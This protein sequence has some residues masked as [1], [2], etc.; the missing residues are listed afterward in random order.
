M[1]ID[2]NKTVEILKNSDDILILM[3]ASP[4]GDTVGSGYA[5]YYALT[6]MGKRAQLKCADPIPNKYSYFT[7][8]AECVDFEPNMIIAI[9]VADPK[10]LGEALGC[11][12]D[13][14]DLNIDH[15]KSNLDYAKSTYVIPEASSTCE[16]MFDIISSITEITPCIAD[17]LYTGLITDSGCFMYSCTSA[18]THFVGAK[19]IEKGADYVEINRRMFDTKTKARILVEKAVLNDMRF[20]ADDRISLIAVDQKLLADAGACDEDIEGIASISRIVEGVEIG[21][22]LKQKA[23]KVYKISCRTTKY[24]DAS[25]LC[26]KFGGGGHSRA[27]G[28]TI[29]GDKEEVIS[30]FVEEAKK[31]L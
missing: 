19:L 10:L 20:F 8:K 25:D 26:A 4:D 18:N 12:I 28:C 13:K 29:E 6:N 2:F 24:V 21:V 15:H 5:L 11:Y 9:D 3:H 30:R 23:D 17:C 14:V 1:N 22:M 27:A 16:I 31:Q 7:N